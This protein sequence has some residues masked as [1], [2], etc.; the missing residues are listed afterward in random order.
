MPASEQGV[1]PERYKVIPRTAI[2]L[3]RGEAYLLLKGSATKRIWP[4]CYNG[5]GGHIDR[6]ED[7]MTSARRELREETGL[8]ADLWLCG[9]VIVDAGE[10]GVSLYVLSG[11]VTGGKLRGSPEGLAE[12]IPYDRVG[13]LPVVADLPFLLGRIHGMRRGE[14]PFAARS[15]YDTNGQLRVVFAG[16][17]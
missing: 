13:S 9:T 8:E 12:W 3:R 4:G 2:F 10:I 5:I 17:P 6:G 16:E 14:P 1:D 15:C 11:E 7:V